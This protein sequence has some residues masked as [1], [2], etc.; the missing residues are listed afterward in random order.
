MKDEKA[1]KEL[2]H[3]G[4]LL[5]EKGLVSGLAGNISLRLEGGR[6]LIT[7]SGVCKGMLEAEKLVEMDI[8]TGELAGGGRPSI[9]TPFHPAFYRGRPDVGAV[10]HTHPEYC[11]VL[12]LASERLRPAMT[13]ES[14]LYLGQEIPLIPYTTPGTEDLARSIGGPMS[15][16]NAYLLEKHG[17][18]T[19]GRDMR[20]AFHRM[21]A[22]EFLAKLQYRV[23]V[24][25]WAADLPPEEVARIMRSKLA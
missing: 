7:P 5:Y 1:R 2:V 20:E 21:E 15:W 16:S 10:V 12:A 23:N 11:T 4:K 8:A 25:G 9:E 24:I 17:A 18:I 19:V 14:L 6:M 22:M 3:Y 13:P